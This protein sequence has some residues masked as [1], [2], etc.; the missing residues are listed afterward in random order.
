MLP[1]E[2]QKDLD[3]IAAMSA[4]PTLLKT[5]REWTGLRYTLVARVLPERWIACAVHDEIDFGLGVGGELDVATTLC[6]HVRDS[7]QPIVIE[8]V[9]HDPVYCGHP[10]PKM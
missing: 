4:V 8:D 3:A 9:N 10:T 1:E 6:C 2:L 5:I 7:H